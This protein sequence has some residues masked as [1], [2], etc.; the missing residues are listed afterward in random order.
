MTT[1]ILPRCFGTL[2]LNNKVES[3]ND[4]PIGI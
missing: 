2:S 3:Q 4:I 1:L